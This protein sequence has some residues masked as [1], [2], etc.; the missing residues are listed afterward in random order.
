MIGLRSV[1]VVWRYLFFWLLVGVL[2]ILG[3]GC[4]FFF[5]CRQAALIQYQ[6][7]YLLVCKAVPFHLQ[8]NLFVAFFIVDGTVSIESLV[9]STIGPRLYKDFYSLVPGLHQNHGEALHQAQENLL[10][11]WASF[12]QI[13]LNSALSGVAKEKG[14]RTVSSRSWR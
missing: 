1:S 13:V 10:L 4:F 14:F 7:F 8:I 2:W 9:S 11:W 3:D 6:M 5:S 12:T